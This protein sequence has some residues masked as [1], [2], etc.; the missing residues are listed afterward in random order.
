MTWVGRC[1]A[2]PCPP[3]PPAPSRALLLGALVVTVRSADE[4][5]GLRTSEKYTLDISFPNASL[6]ADTIY[7]A[8]CAGSACA[9]ARGGAC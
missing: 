3:P 5:L 4:E 8:V 1:D 6:V 7:G 9:R 2:T